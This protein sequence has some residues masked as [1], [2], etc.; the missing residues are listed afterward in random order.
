LNGF[1]DFHVGDFSAT[2][3][4]GYVSRQYLDNTEN[5]D[6]SLPAFTRTDIHLSY[7]W[8]ISPRGLKHAIFGLDL[9]NIFNRRYA[10]SG[11]V[12]SAIVGDDYPEANRYYQIGYVP[13]AGFTIMGN[14]TLK[15]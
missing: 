7:D 5:K 15:F 12:Y 13:M 10:S 8:N 9:G 3:H 14:V 1:A 2:W 6:R 4:T 11:W